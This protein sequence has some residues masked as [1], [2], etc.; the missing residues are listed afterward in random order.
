MIQARGLVKRF[1]ARVA[2]D[3]LS[4][5]GPGAFMSVGTLGP[6]NAGNIVI[7]GLDGVAATRITLA[8]GASISSTSA[9][10]PNFVWDFLGSAGSISIRAQS[11]AL[12]G[13][14]TLSVD[15][16]SE[17]GGGVIDLAVGA[18]DISGGSAVSA[19]TTGFGDAGNRQTTD[20]T[21]RAYDM[22][23]EAF[24]PG[25]N[26]PFLMVLDTPGG[27][28]D[29]PKAQQ[30][31][32]AI[33][34][35]EGVASAS[36]PILLD[37]QKLTLINVFATTS[38]QDEATTELVH[39]LRDE[40]IPPVAASASASRRM[41]SLYSAVNDLRFAFAVTSERSTFTVPSSREATSAM[42]VIHPILPA[43]STVISG[44]PL[45]HACWQKGRRKRED[46]SGA[47]GGS[48]RQLPRDHHESAIAGCLRAAIER[49]SA[50][51][52]TSR[53]NYRSQLRRH[54]GD[55]GWSE[56]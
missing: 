37:E 3:N 16:E 44:R 21:R 10:D 36:D 55:A 49:E 1:G 19:R 43:P 45:S 42:R 53:K 20:T 52:R 41:R 8:D 9:I 38:P 24:G 40:T 27:S 28:A 50:A 26:G 34:N 39:R 13:G 18:L 6:G 29:L 22:L 11:L 54:P 17:E 46:D 51:A 30:L 12:E 7:E 35:T 2:V 15:T 23:S 4:M 56:S 5:Q 48:R 33:R 31:T 32:D 14:S 47:D 25:F